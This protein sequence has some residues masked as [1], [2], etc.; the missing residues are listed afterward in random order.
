MNIKT[1][2][3]S[4]FLSLLFFCK[5]LVAG[6]IP[7]HIIDINNKFYAISLQTLAIS[8][9]YEGAVYRDYCKNLSAKKI[10]RLAQMER[11][12]NLF[13][14]ALRETQNKFVNK[15]GKHLKSI[16]LIREVK[17]TNI[18]YYTR[19][20]L[21]PMLIIRSSF[22]NELKGLTFY[23]LC[24]TEAENVM[25]RESYASMVTLKNSFSQQR[26]QQ[27]RVNNSRVLKGSAKGEQFGRYNQFDPAVGKSAFV[28]KF[29]NAGELELLLPTDRRGISALYGDCLK[30]GANELIC[31]QYVDLIFKG[32]N[33]QIYVINVGGKISQRVNQALE[34]EDY[35]QL[36]IQAKNGNNRAYKQLNKLHFELTN[37]FTLEKEQRL[38]EIFAANLENASGIVIFNGQDVIQYSL[39]LTYQPDI[40]YQWPRLLKEKFGRPDFNLTTKKHINEFIYTENKSYQFIPNQRGN[41]VEQEFKS[42]LASAPKTLLKLTSRK[43][44]LLMEYQNKTSYYSKYINYA[45]TV[46]EYVKQMLK[47]AEQKKIKLSEE[48]KL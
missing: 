5:V 1:R 40:Y 30:Y 43:N 12:Q 17:D 19:I 24:I 33:I 6:E 32:L 44:T 7:F 38:R 8:F 26:Q 15:E 10:W 35:K 3:Y 25:P 14:L 34:T 37:Q 18:F 46:D 11:K 47:T 22:E 21:G 2:F 4:V 23:P 27:D 39:E 42:W 20:G 48:F 45:A 36:K 13:E 28:G 9:E 29:N 31:R 16:A 41:N